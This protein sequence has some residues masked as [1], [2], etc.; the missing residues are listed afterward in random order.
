MATAA[1]SAAAGKIDW[2]LDNIL[3]K[4]KA[5]ETDIGRTTTRS[6]QA[7]Q[8]LSLDYL[9]EINP[10]SAARLR[11][12]NAIDK[13]KLKKNQR[14]AL[15]DEENAIRSSDEANTARANQAKDIKYYDRAN[16]IQKR[17][18]NKLKVRQRKLIKDRERLGNKI[19]KQLLAKQAKKSKEKIKP[20]IAEQSVS[21]F[22]ARVTPLD[23]IS[24]SHYGGE[25]YYAA[26]LR[27][28]KELAEGTARKQSQEAFDNTVD[29]IKE[30]DLFEVAGANIEKNMTIPEVEGN[31]FVT[32]RE[33]IENMK[34]LKE[35]E[36]AI[37]VCRT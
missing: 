5:I 8:K 26:G 13:S 30:D 9:E 17:K 10:V 2:E 11:E 16:S 1:T 35:I 36:D 24:S 14:K 3:N 23:Y 27:L 33:A 34:E 4:I 28:E 19:A 21:P 37:K 12:I 31:G 32:V 18:I 7:T 25:G 22:S 20:F 15:A 6:A 29:T